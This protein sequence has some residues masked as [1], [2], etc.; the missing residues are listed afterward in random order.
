MYMLLLNYN[1]L[2]SHSLLY[3][4]TASLLHSGL[5]WKKPPPATAAYHIPG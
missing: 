1:T 4:N 2:L 5:L 3:I